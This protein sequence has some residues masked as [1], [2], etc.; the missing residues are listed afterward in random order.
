MSE[1]DQDMHVHRAEIALRNRRRGLQDR[2]RKLTYAVFGLMGYSAVANLLGG[3]GAALANSPID[4]AVGI[5]LAALYGFGA[6][7]VWKDDIGWWPVA[8]PAGISIVLVA[9]AWAAGLPMPVP[10]LI[11]LALLVLVPLRARA[12]KA[13]QALPGASFAT[14]PGH[15][16]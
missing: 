8:V 11:N 15:S 7:R 14:S 2:E 12:A 1:Q 9:A 16:A 10:L 3:L 13:V 5:A 4:V 6:L